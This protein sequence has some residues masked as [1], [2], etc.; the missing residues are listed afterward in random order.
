MRDGIISKQ[1][2]TDQDHEAL[3]PHKKK[4][5]LKKQKIRVS[6]IDRGWREGNARYRH[7][8]EKQKQNHKTKTRQGKTRQGK[9][10]Q[11]KTRQDKRREVKT[12]QFKTR[13]GK[14]RAKR[15][16]PNDW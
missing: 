13:Q 9:T 6:S 2:R 15:E 7:D 10:R 16:R 5:C 12:R 11:E 14:A 1:H 8:R 3:G 4:S